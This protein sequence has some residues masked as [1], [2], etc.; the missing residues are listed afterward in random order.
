MMPVLCRMRSATWALVLLAGGGL[1]LGAVALG[2][3]APGSAPAKTAARSAGELT[4][5]VEVP[6]SATPIDPS[7]INVAV[8]RGLQYLRR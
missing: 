7:R 1:G 3:E 6:S 4:G 2:P 5:A 8:Q